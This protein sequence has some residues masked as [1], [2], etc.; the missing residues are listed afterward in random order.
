M[1]S[2]CFSR[3]S[4]PGFAALFTGR[5]PDGLPRFSSRVTW[6]YYVRVVAYG[7]I[8]ANYRFP[9]FGSGGSYTVDLEIDPAV[10]QRPRQRCS[11]ASSSRLPVPGSLD[12]RSA[13]PLLELLAIGNWFIALFLP[14]PPL[15]RVPEGMQRVCLFCLRFDS[16]TQAYL[17]LVNARYPGVR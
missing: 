2:P 11:S 9:P 3:R 6:V 14:P 13:G 15:G 4:S 8:V 5:V 10:E 17:F 16:R 1:G 7:T 12:L